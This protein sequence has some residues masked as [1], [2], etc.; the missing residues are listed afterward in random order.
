MAI[1]SDPRGRKVPLTDEYRD[2]P[3]TER[4]AEMLT[5]SE[6]EAVA[7]RLEAEGKLEDV[8]VEV[9][10]TERGTKKVTT[11]KDVKTGRVIEKKEEVSLNRF[12]DESGNE[13]SPTKEQVTGTGGET[14]TPSMK[15]NIT[16][17]NVRVENVPDRNTG[18]YRKAVVRDVAK[19]EY[20]SV[21]TRER[22]VAGVSVRQQR[23]LQKQNLKP[24]AVDLVTQDVL[25]REKQVDTLKQKPYL[26]RLQSS[27]T[28]TRKAAFDELNKPVDD[29]PKDK[30]GNSQIDERSQDLFL[31][32]DKKKSFDINKV[33]DDLLRTARDPDRRRL[34]AKGTLASAAGTLVFATRLV[35]RTASSAIKQPGTFLK[36]TGASI[37][38]YGGLGLIP[39]VGPALATGV[40]I[41]TTGKSVK[42]VVKRGGSQEEI[43]GTVLFSAGVYKGSKIIARGVS[44]LGVVR[45]A[46]TVVPKM[47]SSKRGAVFKQGKRVSP[48][49]KIQMRKESLN[50]YYDPRVSLN[51]GTITKRYSSTQ[52]KKLTLSRQGSDIIKKTAMTETKRTGMGKDVR[53][54]SR[55]EVFNLYTQGVTRG[56]PKFTQRFVP[57]G[58]SITLKGSV[59]GRGLS[60]KGRSVDLRTNNQVN[61]Q[62]LKLGSETITLSGKRVPKRK[63]DPVKNQINV[64]N[65]QVAMQK[66]TS[67]KLNLI[68][69][70]KRQPTVKGFRP[71]Q[72]KKIFARLESKRA[73]LV[74]TASL[75][76]LGQ[77][78]QASARYS[79]KAK[80]KPVKL[81]TPKQNNDQ[82]NLEAA[83]ELFQKSKYRFVEETDYRA[84]ISPDKPLSSQRDS[85]I[86]GNVVQSKIT[87]ELKP[88]SKLS[89]DVFQNRASVEKTAS[90]IAQKSIPK[91]I[92]SL[93]TDVVQKVIVSPDVMSRSASRTSQM[94]KPGQAV[95]SDMVSVIESDIRLPDAVPKRTPSLRSLRRQTPARPAKIT[96]ARFV[97]PPI[98]TANVPSRALP[99]KKRP[100][101]RID[102]ST[103]D[104]DVFVRRRGKFQRIAGGRNLSLARAFEIGAKEARNSAAASIKVVQGGEVVTETPRKLRGF[105]RSKKEEGVFIEENRFRIDSPGELQEITYKGIMSRKT[106]WL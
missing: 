70:L 65:A 89:Q 54:L 88:E 48:K 90:N 24:Y 79:F 104:I 28:S 50:Q 53:T 16:P 80:P 82:V 63:L 64:N 62:V 86:A 52:T 4:P 12:E 96:P 34:V 7:R 30:S 77:L 29:F 11:R 76:E 17:S 97:P 23:E 39:V 21:P 13:V 101:A 105:K 38:L 51:R 95:R 20:S 26:E 71:G 2:K 58:S 61:T 55:K 69:N 106:R 41:G 36:Q 92:R 33:S 8:Q 27:F 32:H 67:E 99:P 31:S 9:T 15:K 57:K 1:D 37:A 22:N 59:K 93:E 10:E 60:S 81:K 3:L 78:A 73:Q 66:T 6:R 19:E 35:G 56:T 75:K 5:R 44:R 91:Q 94:Q 25:Y 100:E 84:K 87:Q 68:Q 102:L 72:K 103:Q 45:N 74:E 85:L 14:L 83:A 47:L 49:S 46:R 43:L 18:L 42:D 40:F 98:D